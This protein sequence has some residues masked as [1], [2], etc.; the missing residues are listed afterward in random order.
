MS[1]VTASF[2]LIVSA[3]LINDITAPFPNS[4]EGGSNKA[5]S[6]QCFPDRLNND[7]DSSEASPSGSGGNAVP[8]DL[9]VSAVPL[10]LS[11]SAGTSGL[12]EAGPSGLSDVTALFPNSNEGDSNKAYSDQYFPVFLNNDHDASAHNTPSVSA[13]LILTSGFNARDTYFDDDPNEDNDNQS[14]LDLPV[15]LPDVLL[16]IQ[17]TNDHDASP[18]IVSAS[19]INDVTAPFPNPNEGDSNNTPSVFYS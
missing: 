1:L 13:E 19:L 15:G 5:Y 12:S 10:N 18:N 4:N 16:N 3:S 9:S 11:V 7:H 2:F 6:D 8:L 17:T 14:L